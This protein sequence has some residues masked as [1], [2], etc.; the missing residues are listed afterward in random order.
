M[1]KSGIVSKTHGEYMT[2]SINRDSACGENCAACGLCSNREMNITL[3]NTQGFM[4][5]DKVRLISDDKKFLGHSALGYLSL[6]VL[7]IL[8]GA[9]G[10]ALGSQW[11]AFCC[12]LLGLAAGILVLRLFLKT[13]IEIKVEK[14]EV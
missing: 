1:E 10:T 6:T 14:I 9:I 7:I 8:G 5:G 11:Y 13:N 12:A 2:V 3:K 4:P